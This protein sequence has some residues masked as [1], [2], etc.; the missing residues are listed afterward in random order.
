MIRP[1]AAAADFLRLGLG[2]RAALLPQTTRQPGQAVQE[3]LA[4]DRFP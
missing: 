3:R 4:A 1:A 2:P